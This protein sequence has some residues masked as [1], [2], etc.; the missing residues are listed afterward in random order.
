MCI[1][2]CEHLC[3]SACVH[4]CAVT[5]EPEDSELKMSLI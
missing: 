2:E 3:V 5:G 1:Y 4:V